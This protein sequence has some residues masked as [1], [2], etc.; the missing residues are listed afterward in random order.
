MAFY[1]KLV[2]SITEI[3]MTRE[4]SIPLSGIQNARELGG[5]VTADGR[6]VRSGVL[7]RTASLH[8][9][10]DEDIR[11]L[12]DVFRT[13][14]IIDFRMPME[15]KGAEDPAIPGAEYRH[16]NVIDLSALP[17]LQ[18][19]EIDLSAIDIVQVVG[20]SEQMGFLNERMYIGFLTS[21]TG[22]AAY[23]A[24]FRLL[25]DADPDRAVLWHCTGGKDRT[26]LA[27]MLLL[28]AFGV[29]EE[30][31][32]CDYLLTN[33]FNEHRIALT[34]QYLKARGCDD[35][36]IE[37][38]VIVFDAVDERYMRNA[39]AYLKEEFGS[40][41]GYLCDGLGLSPSELDSLRSKYLL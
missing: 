32:V 38:A 11:T 24:F 10:T 27:A 3:I 30:T 33:T 31:V 37:K 4:Y 19:Q 14:Y 17:W 6:T 18:D 8:G 23:A 34:R 22:R 12:T 41:A 16:L 35:A 1:Q 15:M 5:Y 21:G 20:L 40:V 28:S 36:L 13:Q 9:C 29:D 39:I 2:F 7:L 25:L 26:G